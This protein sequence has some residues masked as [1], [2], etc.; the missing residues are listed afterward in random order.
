MTAGFWHLSLQPPPRVYIIDQSSRISNE[1]KSQGLQRLD[2][3]RHHG[4]FWCFKYKKC[5][6]DVFLKILTLSLS[7][8]MNSSSRCTTLLKYFMTFVFFLFISVFLPHSLAVYFS[9]IY[10][11]I[12]EALVL[13]LVS[14]QATASIFFRSGTKPLAIFRLELRTILADNIYLNTRF[15][16]CESNVSTWVYIFVLSQQIYFTQKIYL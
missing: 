7:L 3:R 10:I 2:G 16:P 12:Q 9:I 15:F 4:S 5:Y 13:C 14:V 11:Q 8:S 6:S 1:P